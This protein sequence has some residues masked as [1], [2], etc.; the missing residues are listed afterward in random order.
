MTASQPPENVPEA[1]APEAIG[2]GFFFP[3]RAFR[4]KKK[5]WRGCHPVAFDRGAQDELKGLLN[6]ILK[7]SS[8]WRVFD[9]LEG[10]LRG[11]NRLVE[12]PFA[13]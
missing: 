4:E 13:T 9:I 11:V 2:D 8:C 12:H 7:Y 1:A 10:R 5:K 6:E 3:H